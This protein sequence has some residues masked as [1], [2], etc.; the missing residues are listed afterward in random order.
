MFFHSVKQ[1]SQTPDTI[2]ATRTTIASL[3]QVVVNWW[4][5]PILYHFFYM[6]PLSLLLHCSLF[7]SLGHILCSKFCFKMAWRMLV[8]HHDHVIKW[9][10]AKGRCNLNAEC[11]AI[12]IQKNDEFC[13]LMPIFIMFSSIYRRQRAIMA[14]HQADL[15]FTQ[16]NIVI[17]IG[18]SFSCVY[19]FVVIQN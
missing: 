10:S 19:C 1:C 16:H 17:S 7:L 13:W 2:F 8:I 3:E 15:S 18:T 4:C 12:I 11:N 5:P 14:C 9:L 6:V